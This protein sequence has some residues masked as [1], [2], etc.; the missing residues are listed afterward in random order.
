M[1]CWSRLDLLDYCISLWHTLS[2]TTSGHLLSNSCW[3]WSATRLYCGPHIVGLLHGAIPSTCSWS[4]WTK[5][6]TTMCHTVCRRLSCWSTISQQRRISPVFD[7][8]WHSL[9]FVVGI[10]ASREHWK[11]TRHFGTCWHQLPQIQCW[12]HTERESRTL[13]EYSKKRWCCHFSSDYQ[14]HIFGHQG[15]VS[16]TLQH[17]L[18]QANANFRRLHKWL[19]SRSMAIKH[20]LRLWHCCI[21]PTLT[22]GLFTVG[23]TSMNLHK[24]Q[25]CMYQMLRTVIGD[26]AYV[27]RHTHQQVL[28]SHRC[29][30]PLQLLLHGIRT[31]IQSVTQRREFLQSD[32]I[33]G[34]TQW[35]A[36][37]SAELLVLSEFQRGTEVPV[38]T[39]PV[40]EP[41]T[42]QMHHCSLCDF[43]TDNMAN[44]SRH[45]TNIHNLTKLRTFSVD[46]RR[47]AINGIPQCR[48]CHHIFTTWSSFRRHIEQRACQDP[49][50]V[51]RSCSQAGFSTA[52][53]QPHFSW[54]GRDSEPDQPGPLCPMNSAAD[55]DLRVK[56]L[57]CDLAHLNSSAAGQFLLE[58]VQSLNWT[59]LAAND[60]ACAL[61]RTSCALCGVYVGQV[62]ELLA[63]LKLYHAD[64]MTH[65][66]AKSAQ[67]TLVHAN[68]SPCPF[69][70][71]T[72]KTGH[73][74]PVL[75]QASLLLVNGADM[76]MIRGLACVRRTLTCEICNTDHPNVKALQKHL[77]DNHRLAI[78]DWNPS[79]DSL[80]GQPQ[81]AHC[82]SQHI[83][84]EGLKRHV[85]FGHCTQFDYA[86][87]SETLSVDEAVA[88]HL[89]DGTIALWLQDPANRTCL[90]L[91][92]LCCGE[93]YNRAPDLAAHL[94]QC[95]GGLWTKASP[96]MNLMTDVLQRTTGCICNPSITTQLRAHVCIGY[97]QL[98]M[99]FLRLQ[100]PVL[101]PFV[102]SDDTIQQKLHCSIPTD[103]R[104]I[105]AT[106]LLTRA[107]DTLW[108]SEALGAF[109][110]T[111]CILCGARLHAADLA[112]HLHQDHSCHEG[113]VKH[114]LTQMALCLEPHDDK[115][116]HCT[117]CG[118]AILLPL[119][120]DPI[121]QHQALTVHLQGLC[122]TAIQCALLLAPDGRHAQHG[123]RRA[124]ADAGDIPRHG[125]SV[126]KPP[127]SLPGT[128]CQKTS[129]HSS[130]GANK[131]H[132]S[133]SRSR[134]QAAD[135]CSPEI[136]Q[137][138]ERLARARFIRLFHDQ[139]TDVHLDPTHD[140]GRQMASDEA[141]HEEQLAD[142]S[143]SDLPH[144]TPGSRATGTCPQ[145][146]PSSPARC[147][148]ADST[149]T[150]YPAE[151][152]RMAFPEV[153]PAEEAA[154]PGQCH[155]H[156]SQENGA[157]VPGLGGGRAVGG[158][159]DQIPQ[160]SPKTAQDL[161]IPWRLK[162][163]MRQHE[164]HT[165][166][167]ALAH[168][169]VW[170]LLGCTMKRHSLQQSPICQLLQGHVNPRKGKG[171]GKGKQTGPGKT[172]WM[173]RAAHTSQAMLQLMHSVESSPAWFWWMTQTGATPT[174]LS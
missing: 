58:A 89:Q 99:Q 14:C 39:S 97:K 120:S 131:G 149:A 124:A 84:L 59:Q 9:G 61:L 81:C 133:R 42:R 109:L 122:P 1:W 65:V 80:G 38:T 25:T 44:L 72:F 163:S 19:T 75:L 173:P 49:F 73:I 22:Y 30:T 57:P 144:E 40:E 158:G 45:Y 91:K 27:T 82:G 128:S 12:D 135:Q 31:Q 160:P 60:S 125:D 86:R 92:C 143:P 155:S 55:D 106:A 161:L 85:T 142:P 123:H 15:F 24:L 67:L 147:I 169:G 168:N 104:Q 70:R 102:H 43:G 159:G 10:W 171:K 5:L 54:P 56:L 154:H 153:V 136:G 6:D 96:L 111:T 33:V 88:R 162:V 100:S 11:V 110:R 13:L 101:V 166:L 126:A 138:S 113:Y 119:G 36:L 79:R 26:H 69:C 170:Q 8:Y 3:R 141:R 117:A 150:G 151:G 114:F 103:I 174:R 34:A 41:K 108:N 74:C 2:S 164:A 148:E 16:L 66:M 140:P 64:L 47:D 115:C 32:D 87:S 71:R 167:T 156:L 93:T 83:T 165:I 139:G 90:T 23:L 4:N 37:Y 129:P 152:R 17:R 95:H 121:K 98:A 21:L 78:Q 51:S 116:P 94:Q 112:T 20:R 7:Q 76:D 105:I 46:F 132:A 118:L 77:R 52:H 145:D 29:A 137:G 107:F 134:P 63:H 48:Y 68:Q 157:V 53:Q 35:E 62:R 127:S 28:Q 172:S 50:G 18:I 146:P 130:S